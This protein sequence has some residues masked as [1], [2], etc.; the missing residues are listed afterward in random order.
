M[1]AHNHPPL[2]NVKEALRRACNQTPQEAKTKSPKQNSAPCGERKRERER[3]GMEIDRDNVREREWPEGRERERGRHRESHRETKR[4]RE[5]LKESRISEHLYASQ[6]FDG[7]GGRTAKASQMVSE[8]LNLQGLSCSPH[9]VDKALSR[10][11]HSGNAK[12]K[13]QRNDHSQGQ[14]A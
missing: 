12:D 3:A 5:S 9:V 11:R 7:K 14:V 6:V 8:E 4:E 13:D 1:A 10:P 2:L